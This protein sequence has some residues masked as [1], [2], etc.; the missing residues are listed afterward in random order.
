MCEEKRTDDRPAEDGALNSGRLVSIPFE[1]IFLQRINDFQLTEGVV[2]ETQ[3]S[4]LPIVVRD[5]NTDHKAKD[6][7]GMQSGQS[8]HATRGTNIL[9]ESVSRT[10]SALGT[11]AKEE[12]KHRFRS[13]AR[14][15]DR[16]M[17]GEAFRKLKRRATPGIDGVTY[18]EYAE[19]L[20][21]NLLALETRLK[22]GTYRAQ[23]VKRRWIAKAGSKKLRPL[24]IPVLEDKI[25]QQAVRMI[26]E[27]IWENDFA[28]ESIGYRPGRS[29]RHSTQELSK[30]LDDG[31]H[32]WVVEA[33][34]RG[35]LD[36]SSYYTLVHGL[37]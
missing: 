25:V 4:D 32:R 27:P 10:L 2:K 6:Q 34:I 11:K 36:R 1:E 18:G 24:G 31:K 35:F 26:L 19:N 12:P 14:L 8:T 15:L 29:P 33:D 3:E 37:S 20:D 9:N 7:A 23:P 13:L 21:E 5:G 22:Q 30:K 28:D 17:L 16:Q